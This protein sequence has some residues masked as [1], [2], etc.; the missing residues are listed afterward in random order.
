METPTPSVRED[1]EYAVMWEMRE[2]MAGRASSGAA[3]ELRDLRRALTE[4][5]EVARHAVA[6]AE[7]QAELACEARDRAVSEAD[8]LGRELETARAAA[9]RASEEHDKEIRAL[10]RALVRR[11]TTATGWP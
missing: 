8:A 2:S 9:R 4:D 7:S 10:R 1:L 11:K 5:C 6:T 3:D